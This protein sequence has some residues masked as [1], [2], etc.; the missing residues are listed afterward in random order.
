MTWMYAYC[1]FIQTYCKMKLLRVPIFL[2]F[3][4]QTWDGN[5]GDP[6]EILEL[7]RIQQSCYPNYYSNLQWSWAAFTWLWISFKIPKVYQMSEIFIFSRLDASA[8]YFQ[9]ARF[10]NF[11]FKDGQTSHIFIY[12]WLVAS[13]S[14]YQ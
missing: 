8:S 14:H 11:A 3:H 5:L 7:F 4:R 1:R 6:F 13:D 2:F 12:S 9:S 10:L